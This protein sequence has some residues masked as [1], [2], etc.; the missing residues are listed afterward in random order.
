VHGQRRIGTKVAV[1]GSRRIGAG[2]AVTV[3]PHRHPNV[4]L[5]LVLLVAAKW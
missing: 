5:Q 2:L 4:V 1:N 3:M